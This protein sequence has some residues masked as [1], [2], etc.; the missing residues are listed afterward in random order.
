MTSQSGMGIRLVIAG[1]VQ[2]VGYRDWLVAQAAARNV[3]GWVRNRRDGT[4]EALLH[5]DSTTLATL[6]EACRQGPPA[7]RVTTI[8]QHPADPPAHPGFHRL[9]TG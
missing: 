9:P 8:E 6:V 1:R 2:M 4:V 7:A 5:G 3:H